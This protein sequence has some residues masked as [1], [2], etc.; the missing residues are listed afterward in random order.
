[1]ISKSYYSVAWT[2]LLAIVIT[3]FAACGTK[4]ENDAEASR[5]FDEAAKQIKEK[6]EQAEYDIPPP[7]EIPY[8]IQNTGAD[9]NPDIVNDP[10]KVD[11]YLVSSKK[12]AFN[13][14]V[15][16]TDI[17][18]LSSYGKTQE[19]LNFMDATLKLTDA[20]GVQDAIDFS[21]LERFERNLSSPDSLAGIVNEVIENSDQFLNKNDR[22]NMAAMVMSGT[23]IESLYIA[24]QIIDTYPKDMLSDD[25]RLNVLSPMVQMLA[26]QKESLGD[27]VD[28]LESIEDKD[29]WIIATT[30]SMRELYDT[31]QNFD[32][33]EKIRDGK[34]NEVLNDETLSQL[35]SQVA[36]IRQNIVY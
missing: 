34:G 1:M 18:Y 29:D 23:F 2:V 3:F 15:Y 8:I 21:V 13:L 6:V 31:Y 12:A 7:A 22:T 28:L 24:T 35:T 36:S 19:A 16:A 30:N 9:F 27:V 33:M 5:E 26:K 17:G 32:P 20:V 10:A 11:D 4:K 14:G 25:M